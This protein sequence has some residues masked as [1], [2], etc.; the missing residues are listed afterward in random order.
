M[1]GTLLFY[2]GS[3]KIAKLVGSTTGG[4]QVSISGLTASTNVIIT[5]VVVQ[6]GTRVSYFETLGAAIYMYPLGNR[7]TKIQLRGIGYDNCVKGAP[8]NQTQT[9]SHQSIQD[10]YDFYK[11]RK[12]SSGK[13][14]IVPVTIK[15]ATTSFVAF[16]EELTTEY[17]SNNGLPFGMVRF[18]ATL[19]AVPKD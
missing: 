13:S 7:L 15:L 16:L 17:D 5:G 2:N 18:T 1:A 8:T 3:G 14:G 12:P 9:A 6:Q 10:F 4:F 19:S 11:L